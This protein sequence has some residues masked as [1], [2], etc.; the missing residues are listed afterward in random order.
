[1]N[2]DNT[3][4]DGQ[5]Q[6]PAQ[7]NTRQDGQAPAQSSNRVTTAP[8]RSP[9]GAVQSDVL[10]PVQMSMKDLVRKAVKDKK[11][12]LKSTPRSQVRIV[13]HERV[14]KSYKKQCMQ[15]KAAIERE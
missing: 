7:D 11:E 13:D 1:M 4:Q 8:V 9:D 14:V 3:P 10:S 5:S 2:E 12:K 6:S 15:T